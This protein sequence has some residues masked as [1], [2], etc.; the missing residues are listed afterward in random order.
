MADAPTT[1]ARRFNWKHALLAL[2][3]ALL[4]I[5]VITAGMQVVMG[6]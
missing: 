5:L 6:P 3:L 4:T 1:E 2:G